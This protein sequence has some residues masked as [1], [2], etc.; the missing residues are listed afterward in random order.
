M[1]IEFAEFLMWSEFEV[2]A[3]FRAEFGYRNASSRAY[4]ALFH[5]ARDRLREMRVPVNRVSN[6]GSHEAV[7]QTIEQMGSEGRELAVN[8]RRLKKFRHFCD[9]DISEKLSPPRAHK[10]ILE[11]RLL[12]EML[13]RLELAPA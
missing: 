7:I 4:Y 13:E 11:A 9:Y 10:Q 2:K 12:I 6:G 8:M 3:P 5:A 1:A